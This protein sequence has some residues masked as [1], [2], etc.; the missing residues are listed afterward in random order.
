MYVM[1]IKIYMT[2]ILR[3]QNTTVAQYY[4]ISLKT[5]EGDILIDHNQNHHF[6]LS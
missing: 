1:H 4:N 2:Y 3:L 6:A 5:D